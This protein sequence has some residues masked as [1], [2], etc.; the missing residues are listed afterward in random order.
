MLSVCLFLSLFFFISDMQPGHQNNRNSKR[1]EFP[2]TNTVKSILKSQG[3]YCSLTIA[4]CL[5]KSQVT[6]TCTNNLDLTPKQSFGCQIHLALLEKLEK[7]C[8]DAKLRSS[9]IGFRKTLSFFFV[10]PR[11]QQYLAHRE[12]VQYMS[13][14]LK[15]RK[16][17][18]VFLTVFR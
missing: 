7:F 5:V 15:M 3:T 12:G 8:T 10:I 13:V 16:Y 9:V 14:E 4:S 18:E 17:I 2:M 6:F 1:R 11:P